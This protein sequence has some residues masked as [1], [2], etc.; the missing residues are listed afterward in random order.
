MKYYSKRRP[1]QPGGYP[2]P[3]NNKVVEIIN[4]DIPEY[5]ETIK[6]E[7]RG[8]IVYE[9][10]LTRDDVINYELTAEPIKVK[11]VISLGF[12]SWHREVFKDEDAHI[13]K[14]TEPGPLARE[15]HETLYD[16]DRFDGEPGWPL[17]PEIDYEIVGSFQ[18]GEPKPAVVEK[19]AIEK[20][21]EIARKYGE[22]VLRMSVS[23]LML[24]GSEVFAEIDLEFECEKARRETPENSILSAELI[25]QIIR[26]CYELAQVDAWDI[27]CFI[28]A[29]LE[30][31]GVFSQPGKLL[32]FC[33]NATGDNYGTFVVP[34]ETTDEQIED[35]EKLI[36]DAMD[37]YAKRH[38]SDFSEFDYGE[39]FS[40]AF[41]EVGVKLRQPEYYETIF[42]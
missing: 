2:K 22:A 10:P 8:H 16:S 23:H 30:I 28:K 27:L 42:L 21:T 14:Y 3:E 38:H 20:L 6:S 5:C 13:W 18:T 15:R 4:Y 31:D 35:A 24:K 12:D 39:A 29:Y 11:K 1:I 34:S 19:S 33:G 36:E 7:A 9:K 26:C 41:R 25:E 37:E 40:K 17:N 32:H